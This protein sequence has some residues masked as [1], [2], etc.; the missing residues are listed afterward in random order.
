M[1]KFCNISVNFKDTKILDLILKI[2][3]PGVFNIRF[4]NCNTAIIVFM[5][6]CHM[7]RRRYKS[8]HLIPMFIETPFPS[9]SSQKLHCSFY[10]HI[11]YIEGS[12]A[13]FKN[14][15][16]WIVP[17]LWENPKIRGTIPGFSVSKIQKF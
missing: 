6:K 2:S 16:I 5:K 4:V 3:R 17:D 11:T 8:C 15:K 12:T 7:D 1:Y 10:L 9:L 14:L 13:S